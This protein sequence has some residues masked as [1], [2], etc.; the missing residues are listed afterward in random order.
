MQKTSQTPVILYVTKFLNIG[1]TLNNLSSIFLILFLSIIYGILLDI[2]SEIFNMENVFFDSWDS[3]FRTLI[4]TILGY[5]SMVFLLRVSGKRTLSK[6]NAFDF[7]VTIALGSSL[8]SVALSK[9]ITLADGILVFFLF[10]FLQFIISWLSVRFS[11][12]K[13]I[14]TSKPSLLLYKGEILTEV[15]KKERI[16]KDELYLS[17]REN[18]ISNLQEI[19]II[20]LETTGD[21]TIIKNLD[22]KNP[23]SLKD[24][25]YFKPK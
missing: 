6:M 22:A 1:L 20:V 12:V 17:A 24:V 18:G 4:L 2:H 9:N 11:P 14:V 19:D 15:L 16:S 23:D 10:I 7:I 3:I 13:N 21:M 25:R 8:S 5:I